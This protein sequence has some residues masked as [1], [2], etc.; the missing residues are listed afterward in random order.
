[1]LAAGG[2]IRYDG[3]RNYLPEVPYAYPCHSDQ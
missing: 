2:K 3:R 1:M